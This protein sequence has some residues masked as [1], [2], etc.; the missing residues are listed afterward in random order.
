[1]KVYNI[2]ELEPKE[3]EKFILSV[4]KTSEILFSSTGYEFNNEIV[5]VDK[6]PNLNCNIR[7]ASYNPLT[8][9]IKIRMD[10]LKNKNVDTI[11]KV[12]LHEKCHELVPNYSEE[13]VDTMVQEMLEKYI[14]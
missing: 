1:M 7:W 5:I 2:N 6:V 11:V 8:K 14:K 12:L 9:I 13:E 4:K 3:E 10:L